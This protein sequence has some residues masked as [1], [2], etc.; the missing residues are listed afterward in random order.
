ML[1]HNA[2]Y[3]YKTSFIG[4]RKGGYAGSNSILVFSL[5]V[6][7]RGSHF[8]GSIQSISLK[9][10]STMWAALL[11]IMMI[12]LTYVITLFKQLMTKK[13]NW[14]NDLPVWEF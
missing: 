8:S 2:L 9:I 10:S 6:Q 3:L 1:F 5:A 11:S 14:A 4:F 13:R 12:A 7:A